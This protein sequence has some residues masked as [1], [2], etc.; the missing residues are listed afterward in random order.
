M[1]F[2]RTKATLTQTCDW[3]VRRQVL[4][5][6]P[7]P[8]PRLF[9][10]RILK[11]ML[12]VAR[13]MNCL[14]WTWLLRPLLRM[15]IRVPKVLQHSMSNARAACG[16]I[17]PPDMIILDVKWP[18]PLPFLSSENYVGHL[19]SN[20]EKSDCLVP[21]SVDPMTT[22][23]CGVNVSVL[24]GNVHSGRL[25]SSKMCT[26][27]DLTKLAQT[28]SVIMTKRFPR[29][30]EMTTEKPQKLAGLVTGYRASAW[31]FN[32]LASHVPTQIQ[33]SLNHGERV[34][35][36]RLTPVNVK[37]NGHASFTSG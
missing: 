26:S 24:P 13:S 31:C 9:I 33:A 36:A 11:L 2:S 16:H 34:V 4:P 27:P 7:S 6:S 5:P 32:S 23:T 19:L 21:N 14:H 37:V 25:K 20:S 35:Y 30:T 8:W 3:P 15:A 10:S 22:E 18:A 29:G 1:S 28:L 12:D 17:I